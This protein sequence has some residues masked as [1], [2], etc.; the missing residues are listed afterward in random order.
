MNVR[1][2]CRPGNAYFTIRQVS[3]LVDFSVVCYLLINYD[4]SLKNPTRYENR[5]YCQQPV[6]EV[7]YDWLRNGKVLGIWKADNK[8]PNPNNNKNNVCSRWGGTRSR[9]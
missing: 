9:V 8:N 7:N 1:S 2:R 4:N 3:L 6:T 5:E